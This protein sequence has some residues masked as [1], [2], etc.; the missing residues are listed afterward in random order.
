MPLI[1]RVN[2]TTRFNV[3]QQSCRV[4]FTLPP[5]DGLAL[6]SYNM[7]RQFF[8]VCSVGLPNLPRMPSLI[9]SFFF[10]A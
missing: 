4:K 9:I 2:A 8:G 7:S 1:R 3:L 5:T 6:T 10:D